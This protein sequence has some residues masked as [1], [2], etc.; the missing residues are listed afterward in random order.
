MRTKSSTLNELLDFEKSE[1]DTGDIKYQKLYN[2]KN[3]LIH[4]PA[5]KSYQ[6]DRS[7]TIVS[8]DE[9]YNKGSKKS[10]TFVSWK[11]LEDYNGKFLF[12]MLKDMD[13]DK[14]ETKFV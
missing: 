10:L 9:L 13:T 6:K 3:N 8:T 7:L 4:I 14:L 5:R 2:I 1:F 11:E 12:A